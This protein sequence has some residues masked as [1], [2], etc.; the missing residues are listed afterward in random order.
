[1]G[2]GLRKSEGGCVQTLPICTGL[3]RFGK[4]ELFSAPPMKTYYSYFPNFHN[5]NLHTLRVSRLGSSLNVLAQLFAEGIDTLNMPRFPS[6][7]CTLSGPK[8]CS[9]GGCKQICKGGY[10]K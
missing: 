6:T 7:N 3:D 9:I 2:S 1:M 10:H 5:S 8:E 4:K